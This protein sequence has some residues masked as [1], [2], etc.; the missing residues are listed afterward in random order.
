MRNLLLLL[1]IL[2]TNA[3][4]AQMHWQRPIV[5]FNRNEYHASGQNHMIAQHPNGWLYFANGNGLLE[6]DGV[7]WNL[8]PMAHGVKMTS[9]LMGD[10]NLIYA[11][12]LREFGFFTPNSQGG[13]SY[14]SLSEKLNERGKSNIWN[15]LHV[16]GSVFYQGDVGLFKYTDG[17][18]NF[19]D[20]SGIALSAVVNDRIYFTNYYGL[21][22]IKDDKP[23][24]T[25]S[26]QQLGGT[27]AAM[28]PLR[29]NVLM[30]MT[31]GRMIEYDGHEMRPA[32][33]EASSRMA[34]RK[35]SCAAIDGTTLAIGT[36]DDGLYLVNTH[37]SNVEKINIAN[38]LHDKSLHALRFDVNHNLWTALD[39][40][41]SYIPLGS[42]L[43]FLKSKLES[44]GAGY[45]ACIY[46][47]QLFLG[48]S[49][50]VFRTSMPSTHSE[51]ADVVPQ[52]GMEGQS[53]CLYA[54]DGALFCGGR[55][56]F[57]IIGGGQV[58]N[59]EVTRGVWNA[60]AISCS[61][62]DAVLLGTYWG[63]NIARKTAWGWTVGKKI[64]GFRMS[65]KTVFVEPESNDVWVA[66]KTDGLWRVTLD[67]RLTKA[68]RKKCYNSRLLPKGDNVC[69]AKIGNDIVVASRKGLLRY[70]HTQDRLVPFG[71]LERKLNGHKPYSYIRQAPDGSVWYVSEGMLRHQDYSGKGNR[72]FMSGNLIEDFESVLP[73][74][75]HTA[76]VG[77]EDGFVLVDKKKAKRTPPPFLQIRKLYVTNGK[78]SLA[79]GRSFAYGN[80]PLTI[81]YRDN[82]IRIEYAADSYAPS[83]IVTY[84]YRLV[85]LEDHW[86]D[87]TTATSKEYTRLQEGKYTFEVKARTETG[88]ETETVRLTFRVRP[89]WHRSWWA[90]CLYAMAAIMV[91]HRTWRK[92]KKSR[93]RLIRQQ[94]LEMKKQKEIFKK[95]IGEKAKQIDEQEKQIDKLEKEK[96]RTE[97]QYKSDE[98]M[99]ST[100]NVVRKNEMLQKIRKEA[101]NLS[102]IAGSGDKVALRRSILRLIGQIDVNMEHDSDLKNFESSFD[103][104]HQDFFRKLE[105]R[106]PDITHKDKIL[107][108]YIRM[109]LMS[110]EIA[111]LLNISVRGVEIG[112]YRLRKKLGLEE[113]D[114]LADFL[115]KI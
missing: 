20:C 31:N 24:K 111:P 52:E 51:R 18:V 50:G 44:I 106:A 74:G 90:Y 71:A 85:G 107:C 22:Y 98:L 102:Q 21:S 17:K 78:D 33:T 3:M 56:F 12:G 66:N 82:S 69:V 47:G 25:L 80:E 5:N 46:G 13:L 79:Y 55:D 63:L 59:D 96:L 40:G 110:K 30:V 36:I 15:I 81:S 6:F 105:S 10:D 89:P 19:I 88:K 70:D 1:S 42:R 32:F 7:Y 62:D 91:G 29:G 43:L 9:L 104:V 93:D 11:G 83:R 28:L 4:Q 94:K 92:Y 39:N 95:D 48:S 64:D 57:G 84:K 72:T 23:V 73:V 53:H 16:G 54:H 112:R 37:N 14:T 2:I 41:I 108:A 61:G 26:K 8:Y 49:Q 103:A 77:S 68:L 101:E 35:I 60:Q 114:N 58:K 99:K 75:N 38:G 87:Y 34:S 45:C 109:N 27:I 76:I 97:L 67:M 113:K 115:Q 86:S 65:A 100:L